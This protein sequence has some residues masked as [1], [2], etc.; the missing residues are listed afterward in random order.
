MTHTVHESRVG[1]QGHLLSNPLTAS[2]MLSTPP[3]TSQVVPS[4]VVFAETQA[5]VK[6][7]MGWVRTQ[8]D[9]KFVTEGLNRLQ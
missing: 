2:Q 6:P 7:I 9:L 3:P 4:Q 8:E 1:L 5:I